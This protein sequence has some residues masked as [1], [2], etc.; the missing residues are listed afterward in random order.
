MRSLFIIHYALYFYNFTFYYNL[1]LTWMF[2]MLRKKNV[3]QWN[4]AMTSGCTTCVIEKERKSMHTLFFYSFQKMTFM[5]FLL[6]HARITKEHVLLKLEEW[7][8]SI[9]ALNK[10]IYPRYCKHVIKKLIFIRVW[11]ERNF[12]K[13]KS[14]GLRA[15]ETCS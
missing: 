14:M 15:Q 7:D 4:N 6:L 11:I 8:V 1:T 3:D 2:S 12:C 9:F 10:I 13:Q 5:K